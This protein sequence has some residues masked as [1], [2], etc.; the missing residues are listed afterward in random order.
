MLLYQRLAELS[1]AWAIEARIIGEEAAHANFLYWA[2]PAVVQEIFAHPVY[3]PKW[4]P[5]AQRSPEVTE[6]TR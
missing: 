2:V 5:S 4:N 1:S 6:R 3:D